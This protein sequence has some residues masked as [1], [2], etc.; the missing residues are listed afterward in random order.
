MAGQDQ[1]VESKDDDK[2]MKLRYAGKCRVCGIDIP[3]KAEAVYEKSSKSVRCL[4]HEDST[5]K[6]TAATSSEESM[7]GNKATVSA[8]PVTP[9][10]APTVPNF[11]AVEETSA[12]VFES[13]VAG[14]SA[15][16]EYLKRREAD[17]KVIR[18]K[19]GVLG[20]VAVLLSD[21]KQDTVAWAKGAAGEERM[22]KVLESIKSGYVFVL[23]DRKIPNSKA[24]IDHIVITG[25]GVWVVD[26]K[27][28][29]GR[30]ELVTKSGK[31][32]L[33]VNGRNRNKIVEGVL[34]QQGLIVKA[35]GDIPVTS[36]LCFIEADWPLFGAGFTVR[37][38]HA[39]YPKKLK[40][41]ITDS[42]EGP[43]NP[44]ELRDWIA[45]IF[46]PA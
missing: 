21:E 2:R 35:L 27:K 42:A 1:V 25:S 5:L 17:E 18:D 3:A 36:A 14:S 13:G 22:G 11:L 28:Y 16:R 32:H 4:N 44:V 10:Q 26:A 12:P 34:W 9:V 19:W 30:P 24:N 7:S 41:M 23:H 20:G 38:V 15:R 31:Q 29:K 45:S 43:Y 6:E 46:L 37:G 40:K 33:F 8:A 39:T